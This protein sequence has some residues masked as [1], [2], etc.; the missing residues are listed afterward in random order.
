M[1]IQLTTGCVCDA[2][3]ADG[4]PVIDM[5]AEELKS[6][7]RA[8]TDKVL[9]RDLTEGD[10]SDLTRILSDFVELFCDIREHS[11]EPCEDCGDWVETY[12]MEV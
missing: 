9:S 4:K 7:F 12:E 6:L 5:P 3:T 1:K 11:D 8:V 2:F 10:L